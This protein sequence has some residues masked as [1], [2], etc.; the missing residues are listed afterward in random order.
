MTKEIAEH[1]VLMDAYGEFRGEVSEVT[2]KLAIVRECDDL[3][4]PM[5]G[6]SVGEEW[7]YEG[8]AYPAVDIIGGRRTV[9]LPEPLKV[10]DETFWIELKGYG[11]NGKNLFFK[12]HIE[13]DL[14]YGMYLVNA[15]RGYF[16]L[17]KA[18]DLGLN[19]P[20]AV[21]LLEF[22]RGE[23]FRHGLTG[24]EEVMEAKM[25]LDRPEGIQKFWS[26]LYPELALPE[27]YE[28]EDYF[29]YIKR[30]IKKIVMELSNSLNKAYNEGEG[31]LL[32]NCKQ[33]GVLEEFGGF[34]SKQ[35]V[36]F[37]IRACRSPLRV[38]DSL[39][40]GI[41][42]DRNRMI[43]REVGKTFWL[44]LEHNLLH[45]SPNTGNWTKAGELTDFED[46]IELPQELNRLEMEMH[47]L[48]CHSLEAFFE[49][50]IGSRP[51]QVFYLQTSLRV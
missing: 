28:S 16:L 7:S 37:N 13:G 33:L 6:V 40:K 14:F 1:M 44:L 35:Q 23:Y 32:E 11:A 38:G 30:T 50:L 47:A 21:A 41:F 9:F 26:R 34:F 18:N 2:P 25:V 46:V 19:V 12:H 48:G 10:N 42:T 43:A 15:A 5:L 36:G 24:F 3:V 31:R 45:I 51:T 49:D 8:R 4:S 22:P 29:D 39:D 27:P 17:K 20:K